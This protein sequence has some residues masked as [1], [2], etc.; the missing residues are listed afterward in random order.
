[1]FRRRRRPPR[2][3]KHMAS[4][5]H[6]KL[7]A[8]SASRIGSFPKVSR[9]IAPAVTVPDLPA[10]WIILGENDAL[11]MTNRDNIVRGL[12]A[13][14]AF[15]EQDSVLYAFTVVA[16]TGVVTRVSV[17]DW[18]AS[19]YNTQGE[20]WVAM[21][22]SDSSP[23]S[24]TS[25]IAYN[26][27]EYRFAP[28]YGGMVFTNW[29]NVITS[30]TDATTFV[31]TSFQPPNAPSVTPLA[32]TVAVRYVAPTSMVV[33]L[34]DRKNNELDHRITAWSGLL[35]REPDAS[36]SITGPQYLF[37]D[38]EEG[39]INDVDDAN[40][41][42][43]FDGKWY[44]VGLSND[45]V[46]ATEVEAG[47]PH[48]YQAV[49]RYFSPIGSAGGATSDGRA[50]FLSDMT[51]FPKPPMMNDNLAR[52]FVTIATILLAAAFTSFTLG[53]S[54]RRL[55]SGKQL[56]ITIAVLTIVGSSMLVFAQL[57]RT[58]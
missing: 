22:T 20:A 52:L 56:G 14:L 54:M 7:A 48:A 8:A 26:C 41:S 15:Y 24:Q 44:K 50:A 43:I 42:G 12:E 46:I 13:V 49:V 32:V 16:S 55:I 39:R 9:V 35:R 3:Y 36:L 47:T 57:G 17:A 6:R 51:G 28:G 53:T 34:A 5:N 45:D 37:V 58:F 19:D 10:G 11:P 21:M 2:H 25:G 27:G 31:T 23:S 1:M 38:S 18:E 30:V 40:E 29:S 4:T 33:S